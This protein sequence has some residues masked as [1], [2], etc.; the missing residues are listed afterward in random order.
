MTHAEADSNFSNLKNAVEN[1]VNITSSP[2]WAVG[3]Y[4][5][6]ALVK[7]DYIAYVCVAQTTTTTPGTSSD[8]MSIGNVGYGLGS[9]GDTTITSPANGNTLI[10]D[11]T[12]NRWINKNFDMT[13]R[14]NFV[15]FLTQSLSESKY[16]PSR[17][18]KITGFYYNF[19]IAP[20]VASNFQ[21]KKN[22]T[23]VS[24]VTVPPN[25]AF[26]AKSALDISLGVTDYLTIDSYIA[27]GK[28]LCI[29][30]IYE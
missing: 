3:T 13:F 23:T 6:G 5:Y 14:M 9:L 8:W 10:F 12:V 26:V 28:N 20:G 21:I 17:I 16:Y 2:T 18:I 25:T 1:C 22:G 19:G 29:T 30:F 27:S 11:S 7:Y 4:R 15:G 24:T